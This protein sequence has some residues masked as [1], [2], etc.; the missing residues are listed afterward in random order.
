MFFVK[1]AKTTRVIQE[2]RIIHKRLWGNELKDKKRTETA[3]KAGEDRAI[4]LGLGMVLSSV[5]MYFVICITMVHA[6]ADSVLTEETTCTFL[7]STLTKDINCSYSCGSE[8][9]RSSKY[10]CLQV[11]VSLNTTGR[12]GLLSHNEEMLDVS[13]ECF[14]VPK[15]QKDHTALRVL[16]QNISE[17]LKMHQQVTC[18]HDSSEHQGS[19]LLNRLYGSTSVFHSLFWPS[20][21]LSGGTL[22]I[23]M[24]KLTRYL[25]ILC[26]QIGKV[27]K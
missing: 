27:P 7:N 2:K 26:E 15:C 6:Y 16:I 10:P 5:M 20:C 17:H 18:Y 22:I 8:C 21:M 1:G 12:I 9:W 24:V 19:I 13:T 4:L 14:Y 23:L 11:Y 3:L 25:S